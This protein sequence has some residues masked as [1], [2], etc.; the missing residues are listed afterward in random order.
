MA[1]D[2]PPGAGLAEAVAA[3]GAGTFALAEAGVI[4]CAPIS[5]SSSGAMY[6]DRAAQ[7]AHRLA[8]RLD[9]VGRRAAGAADGR[10]GPGGRAGRA[11]DR[12]SRRRDDASA[13]R[14]RH[15]RP[16]GC[17]AA[18]AGDDREGIRR[19]GS[20][21]AAA[22]S[23]GRRWPGGCAGTDSPRCCSKGPLRCARGGYVVD[24][25][26]SGFDVA[27]RMGLIP[28]AARPWLPDAAAEHRGPARQGHLFGRRQVFSELTGGR[29]LSI[30]RSD[31][32][33]EI[34]GSAMASR[35]GSAAP[36][37][38]A[39]TAA[40]RSRCG[41]GRRA[42]E[43]R[44]AIGADGLHSARARRGFGP[45]TRARCRSAS[46]SPPSPCRLSAARRADLC[47]PHPARPQRSRV[48][49]RDDQTLV[50][51]GVRASA[52]STAGRRAPRPRRAAVARVLDGMGWEA[53]AS[54]RR[55]PT[56]GEIYFD[57]VAQIRMPHWHRGR[58]GAARRR[59]CLRLVARRRRHRAGD[60]RGLCAG[61]EIKRAGG[62][63]Q[64]AFA[65][66]EPRLTRISSASR[67]RPAASPAFSPRA[68]AS[69]CSCATSASI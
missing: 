36:S 25:W 1:P 15:P 57:R 32:S 7:P 26:G 34:C 47:H 37:P 64:A 11:A 56:A 6:D 13:A 59:R 12:L 66:W 67:P 41:F 28:R 19:C 4:S 55:C 24:F 42:S 8:R 62:D 9:R 22:A 18:A 46:P 60:D 52:S 44:P 39:R 29:Y 3:F 51:A 33:A 35:S 61:R 45:R 38:A 5:P 23:P 2:L 53:P 69:A 21:L 31:L 14:P 10:T 20:R 27:E 65:A 68:A 54:R 30:A 58:V 17:L 49:L 16:A 50:A 40:R 48:S 63:P 43:V